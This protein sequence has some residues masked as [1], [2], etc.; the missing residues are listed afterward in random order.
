V[1]R[2]RAGGYEV[3]SWDLWHAEIKP[4]QLTP[5]LGSPVLSARLSGSY[6]APLHSK[7]SMHYGSREESAARC[8]VP[9]AN[10]RA[11][12]EQLCGH[13]GPALQRCAL[14]PAQHVLTWA[15]RRNH[16]AG[17]IRCREH[18]GGSGGRG[19]VRRSFFVPL[20][21]ILPPERAPHST[22]GTFRARNVLEILVL[23][24]HV[25]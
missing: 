12:V 18:A 20:L 3:V 14:V 25:S 17:Q 5:F 10:G 11:W 13:A 16:H 22:P 9:A 8:A 6:W 7:V 15:C 23:E 19:G 21:P 1:K 24:E 4:G 2:A